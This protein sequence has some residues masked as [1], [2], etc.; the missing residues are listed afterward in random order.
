MGDTGPCGRCS[1]IY[2]DRGTAVPG[3]GDFMAD[4]ATDPNASSRSGTTCSW[5]SSGRPMAPCVT[6]PRARSI[7]AWVSSAFPRCCKASLSTYDTELFQ[8]ILRTLSAMASLPYRGGMDASDVSMRVVADHIRATTFLIGDGVVPSNEW[9]GYVLRKIMRRA[10][11]HGRKLGLKD[12]FMFKLVDVV[13]D[14]MGGAY[15]ELRSSR[16]TIA[17]VV[18]SEEERFGIVLTEGLPRLEEVLEQAARGD[19]VVPGEEAFK[20]YDT[21]GLPRDFIEDLTSAQDL[22][23]DTDGFEQAMQRQREMARGKSA[24]SGAQKVAWNTRP[25]AGGA[26]PDTTTISA[27]TTPSRSIRKSSSCS[28]NPMISESPSTSF[29]RESMGLSRS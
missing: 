26:P 24:F 16:D 4:A 18:R 13:V 6:C 12:P 9:R 27:V 28:R 15:P 25:E 22:R 20:L 11:R 17:Q 29:T 21:Y 3:T 10:M 7:R 1:E 8:P 14:E 5:N 23:F 19:K 2:Y